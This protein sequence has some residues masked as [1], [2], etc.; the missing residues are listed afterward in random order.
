[1]PRKTHAKQDDPEQSK[2]FIEAAH[3]SE[4]DESEEAADRAFKKIAP[5]KK[6]EKPR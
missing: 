6:G 5:V 3:K 2:R 4:A 1:M